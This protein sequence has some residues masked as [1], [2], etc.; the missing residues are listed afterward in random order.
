L[1]T[2]KVEKKIEEKKTAKAEKTK[3]KSKKWN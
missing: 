2:R 3:T 1:E